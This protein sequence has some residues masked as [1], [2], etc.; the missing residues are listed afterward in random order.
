MQSK[1]KS[2]CRRV[3]FSSGFGGLDQL[4]RV[5]P[6]PTKRSIKM[7]VNQARMAQLI[8]SV[9]AVIDQH[10]K[11]RVNGKTASLRTVEFSRQVMTESCRRL[12]ALGFFITDISN[13]K[14]KHVYALI[15]SWHQQGLTPKTMQNQLSRLRIFAGWIGKCEIVKPGGLATYLPDVNAQTLKVKTYTEKSKSWTG[16][17]VDVVEIYRRAKLED[18]RLSGMILMA[19][20]F[21]FRKKECLRIKPWRADAG[22]ELRVDGSIAKNGRFR[23]IPI[24][25]NIPYGRFQRW[26]LDEVKSLCKKSE[27]LGWIELTYKG[28]ENR[29]Y[30]Y[31]KKLGVTKMDSG[32]SGHGLRAEF[33]E[34]MAL[35]A[36]LVPPSLGGSIDQ[37]SKDRR[38]EIT[39][40]ISSLLGHDKERTIGAYFSTFRPMVFADGMG[41]RIGPVMVVDFNLEIFATFF[42]N[43]AP[44]RGVDGYRMLTESELMKSTITAVVESPGKDDQKID[45]ARFVELHYELAPRVLKILKEHGLSH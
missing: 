11:Q 1:P 8:K 27:T 4:L 41:R 24:D 29:Y 38:K 33:A 20:A 3:S 45:I 10:A 9:E 43:P 34:N 28:S 13:L 22:H 26:C 18:A 23:S 7:A 16:C 25:M 14:D 19:I 44:I 39:H 12:D 37:M 17:G 32:V 5:R 6:E 2:L 15:R 35:W 42:C 21:G 30:Y 40:S 36:G 31:M